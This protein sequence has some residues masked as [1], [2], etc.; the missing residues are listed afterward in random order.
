MG[1]VGYAPQPASIDEQRFTTASLVARVAPSAQELEAV[2]WRGVLTAKLQEGD[3][4]Q[5]GGDLPCF[6]MHAGLLGCLLPKDTDLNRY[7]FRRI[8]D[9]GWHWVE[10]ETVDGRRG[11]YGLA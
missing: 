4:C 5:C 3:R 1:A 10:R 6:P 9:K 11:D 2:G 7:G 8:L